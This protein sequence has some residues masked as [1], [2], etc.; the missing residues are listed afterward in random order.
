MTEKVATP[1][2]QDDID[3]GDL[4]AL[5]VQSWLRTQPV[6]EAPVR[7]TLKIGDYER[8]IEAFG[9]SPVD[10]TTK[11]V[12]DILAFDYARWR[13]KRLAESVK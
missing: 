10:Q 9:G 8:G 7:I 13:L 11:S 6:F 12:S 1:E 2:K 5:E 4:D 3:W